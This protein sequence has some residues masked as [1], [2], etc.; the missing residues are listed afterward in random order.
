MEA[1]WMALATGFG[2]GLSPWA[3][4]TVGTLLGVPLA[5][6][7]LG[8]ARRVQLGITLALLLAAVPV[9]HLA[10]AQLGARDDGNDI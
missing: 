9:C 10:E 3:S 2:L 5:W 6:W 1:V 8:R 7:L 4:G